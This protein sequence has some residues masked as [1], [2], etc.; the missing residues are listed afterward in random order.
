MGEHVTIDL[1]PERPGHP[2]PADLAERRAGMDA[3]LASGVWKT[4]RPPVETTLGGRRTLRFRPQGPARGTVMHLH[5]GGF[6]IGGPEMEGPF[7]EALA[8]RCGVEVAVPQY[9]LAPEHPF[10][11]GLADALAVLRALRAEIGDGPLVVSGDSAG[12]GLAAALA[13]QGAVRIDGLV[14]LSPWLDTTVTAPSF[15]ENGNDPWF[16]RV[17]ADAAATLYLQGQDPRHPLASPLLAPLGSFPPVLIS[18]GTGEA[19]RDDALRM[20]AR[21]VGLG[22][23]SRLLAIE[24]M[25]H[26]AVVRGMDLPGARETFAET[27]AFIDRIIC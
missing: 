5:G 12:G 27:A 22:R 24:G 3:A 1:P 16:S 23:E 15:A 18:V 11:A 14:L 17:S 20:H 25:E 6:R 9:R 21:L 26:V 10:P 13:V 2:A 4:R 7:A 19:L 8:E